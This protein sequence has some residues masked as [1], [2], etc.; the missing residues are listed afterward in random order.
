MFVEESLMKSLD[1]HSVVGGI[2]TLIRVMELL[3]DD[4][5]LVWSLI[6]YGTLGIIK[7]PME[8]LMKTLIPLQR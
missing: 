4:D 8:T 5:D 6:G 1:P 2:E 3:Y 7:N